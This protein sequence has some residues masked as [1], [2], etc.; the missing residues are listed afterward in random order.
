MR[1]LELPV[2]NM[3]LMSVF[4]D[5]ARKMKTQAMLTLKFGEVIVDHISRGSKIDDSSLN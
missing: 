1:N 5:T 3:K 2:Q 4:T